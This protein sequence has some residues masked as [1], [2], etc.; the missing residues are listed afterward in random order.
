M[1]PSRK[2]EQVAFNTTVIPTIHLRSFAGFAHS[3]AGA[4][5]KA[6]STVPDAPANLQPSQI[7]GSRFRGNDK[8]GLGSYPSANFPLIA[9]VPAGFG[10]KFPGI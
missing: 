1:I 3:P 8:I 4:L 2:L 7:L 9:P 5:A 6:G 10:V